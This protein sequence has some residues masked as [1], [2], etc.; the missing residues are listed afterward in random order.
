MKGCIITKDLPIY[1]ALVKRFN[2]NDVKATDALRR[3]TEDGVFTPSFI[4]WQQAKRKTDTVLTLETAQTVKDVNDI[5][6]FGNLL[7]PDGNDTVLESD[8]TFAEDY[9][10]VSDR[11]FCKHIVSN[12]L[13]D[14]VVDKLFNK[15]E[16]ANITKTEA[17]KKIRVIFASHLVQKVSQTKAISQD[18]FMTYW[19][20]DRF[21]SFYNHYSKNGDGLRSN[22]SEEDAEELATIAE[23]VAIAEEITSKNVSIEEQNLIATLKEMIHVTD[24]DL[25][26]SNDI[27]KSKEF[28][29]DVFKDSRLFRFRDSIVNDV[30]TTDENNAAQNE[31]IELDEEGDEEGIDTRADVFDMSFSV[32]DS[33][34]GQYKTYMLHLGGDLKTYFD[35]L[36]K[37]TSASVTFDDNGKPMYQYDVYNPIGIAD[38]MGAAQCVRALYT[39]SDTT[40]VDNFIESVKRIAEQ[41]PGLE[42][43]I[44][45][46]YDMRND[47]DFAYH[48]KTV[49]GKFVAAKLETSIIN[50]NYIVRVTNN[51]ANKTDALRTEFMNSFRNAILN[52][53][54]DVVKSLETKINNK[55]KEVNE[56]LKD[57]TKFVTI[58]GK[59]VAREYNTESLE[60]KADIAELV[61]FVTDITRMYFPNISKSNILGFVDLHSV[62]GVIN[63][64]DN[65]KELL[66]AIDEVRKGAVSSRAAFHDKQIQASKIRRQNDKIMSDRE[67]GVYRSDA[68]IQDPASVWVDSF[69]S[70]NATKA[71]IRFANLVVNHVEV[72]VNLNSRNA[73]G[74]TSSDVINNSMISYLNTMLNSTLNDK[75]N[76]NSPLNVYRDEIFRGKQYDF[77]NILVEHTEDG[78]TTP[79]LF[80]LVDGKY[81]QTDY[82]TNLLKFHLFNGVRN[83]DNGDSVLYAG[84]PE[85]DYIATAMIQFFNGEETIDGYDFSN[86]F[87]RTPSDAPK[88]FVM[89]APKFKYH[90]KNGAETISLY[91][92]DNRK[93]ADTKIKQEIQKI[94]VYDADAFPGDVYSLTS[95]KI[96]ANT[97][98]ALLK[99]NTINTIRINDST[100]LEVDASDKNKGYLT[101]SCGIDGKTVTVVAQGTLSKQDGKRTLT[102]CTL[103]GVESNGYGRITYP[104]SI[105][106]QLYNHF[107]KELLAKDEITQSLNKRHPIFKCLYRTAVQELQDAATAVD[108][109]LDHVNGVVKSENGNFSVKLEERKLFSQYHHKKLEY[110]DSDG[111]KHSAS[112]LIQPYYERVVDETDK[113]GNPTK[114]YYVNTGYKTLSG[115]VFRSDRFIV[116]GV[117]YME[118]VFGE[119]DN[120]DAAVNILY[121]SLYGNRLTIDDN[122]NVVVSENQKA[123]IENAIENYINAITNDATSRINQYSHLLENVP[124]NNEDIAEFILNYVIAFNNCNDILEG[125]SKFYKSPQDFL[126]RAKEGQGSGVPMGLLDITRQMSGEFHVEVPN[127]FLNSEEMQNIV[128][129][130]H[131]CKQYTTFRAV[132][133][134]NTVRQDEETKGVLIDQLYEKFKKEGLRDNVARRKAEEM[135]ARY[136][137][138]KTNDAQSYITF[139]EWIRRVAAKGQLHKYKPLIEAVLDESK[140]LSVADINEFIQV[141]KHFYYDLHYNSELKVRSPRQI[142]NA[143]FVLVP[144]FIKGTELEQVYNLMVENDIDQLNT[145]EA[146]KAGKSNVLTLWDNDGNLTEENIKD[147]RENVKDAS[148]AVE[149]F[150]YNYLYT[151]QETPNHL[152]SENRFGLQISKKIIDNISSTSQL[153]SRKLEYLNLY[154]QNIKDS[155]S[156]V[157]AEIDAPMDENGDIIVVDG[158]INGIDYTTFLKKMEDELIR[159]GADPNMLDYV[160]LDDAATSD[161]SGTGFGVNTRMPAYHNSTRL[162]FESIAQAV[163]NNAVTRQKLPG[164]HAAQITNIGWKSFG[165]N[166][167]KPYALRSDETKRI[168]KAEYNALS[169][170][171][172]KNYRDTRV[173]YSKRLRYHPDG[174]KYIQVM[175]P[176]SAFGLDINDSVYDSTREQ[177][178]KDGKSAQEIEEEIKHTMLSL[179]QAK[180]LDEFIGYRIPTEG[181]QSMAVMKVVGFTSEAQGSTIVIPDAW[182]AQTGSD[183]DIDSVYGIQFSTRKTS[184]GVVYKHN[185][186]ESDIDSEKDRKN[187]DNAYIDYVLR[188]VTK[189]DRAQFYEDIKLTRDNYKDLKQLSKTYEDYL[190]ELDEEKF[191]SK[192]RYAILLARDRGLMSFIDFKEL[193]VEERNSRESRNN[194]MLQIMI[195]I[196]KSD[197]SLEENLGQSR[198]TDITA[199]RNKMTPGYVEDERNGRAVN[200]FLDQA[201]FHSDA[202]SGLNLKAR[203]VQR[204]TF[205]SLCNTMQPELNRGITIVYEGDEARFLE[206]QKRFD[207]KVDG[208][209]LGL[210]SRL[211]DNRISVTHVKFGWSADN[212]NVLE[213]ILTSYSSQTTAHQLDIIKEGLVPNV[214]EFTFDVYKL[215]PDIGSDYD[216]AIG[217]M[218]QPAIT[219]L[220]SFYNRSNSIFSNE[221]IKPEDEVVKRIYERSGL[222]GAENI[223]QMREQLSLECDNYFGEEY[224][225]LD[226]SLLKYRIDSNNSENPDIIK[227]NNLF[228][229]LVIQEYQRLSSIANDVQTLARVCKADRFGAKQTLFQTR[230]VFEDITKLLSSSNPV[231]A[232]KNGVS[233][234]ERIY[235]GISS[236]VTETGDIDIS[237]YLQHKD[238][239]SEYKP[240]HYFLK[241]VSAVSIVVNQTLFPTQ[242]P[243]FVKIVKAI[244][245]NFRQDAV[246]TE[247]TYN[248]YEKY[249]MSHIYK[250]VDVIKSPVTY[251]PNV[252]VQPLNGNNR[253]EIERIFGYNRTP[254]LTIE[255]NGGFV[256]FV[257]SD[258]NEPNETDIANFAKL[259]PAQ[260]VYFIQQNFRDGLVCKYIDVNLV[261]NAN[262]GSE[263]FGAQ[264]LEFDEDKYD[265]NS[266]RRDFV[267]TFRNSNPLLVL[268]AMDIIKYSY[269]VEGNDFKRRVVNKVV[270]NQIII[271]PLGLYGS[272]IKEALDVKFKEFT[273]GDSLTESLVLEE[274]FIRSHSE[275]KEISHCFINSKD[276]AK[277]MPVVQN[278]AIAVLVNNKTEDFIVK[279]GIG[280]FTTSTNNDGEEVR[281]V[282]PNHYV[283]IKYGK[284]N[285][286][287]YKITKSKQDNV[288]YLTPLNLLQSNEQSEYSVNSANNKFPK[289][290]FYTDAITEYEKTYSNYTREDLVKIMTNLMKDSDGKYDKPESTKLNKL[291]KNKRLNLYDE[292]TGSIIILRTSIREHFKNGFNGSTLYVEMPFL[293]NFIAKGNFGIDEGLLEELD[294]R[295]YFIYRLNLDE[296]KDSNENYL[297]KY[298]KDVHKPIPAEFN[299]L[300]HLIERVRKRG[301]ESGHQGE[302]HLYNVY[303]VDVATSPTLSDDEYASS[304]VEELSET[305]RSL[306]RAANNGENKNAEDYAKKANRRNIQ[307]SVESIEQKLDDAVMLQAEHCVKAVESLLNDTH[308]L[309]FFEQDKETSE[310]M[311]MTDPR[312]MSLVRQYPGVRRQYLKNILQAHQIIDLFSFAKDYTPTEET[313]HLNLYIDKIKEALAKLENSE[314]LKQAE[315]LFVTDYL[316]KISKNPNVRN[317]IMSLLE[318]WHETGWATGLLNDI[319][320]T[321]NPLIQLITSDVMRD[322]RAKEMAGEETRQAFKNKMQELKDEASRLGLS[323]NWDK[324]VDA[325]GKWIEEYTDQ[326]V[327]DMNA[328][329]KAKDD[330]LAEYKAFNGPRYKKAE[331][332]EKYLQAKLAYNKWCLKYTNQEI[333]DEYYY[334][335]NK[336]VESMI[337]PKTGKF[338]PIYVEYCMLNDELANIYSQSVNGELDD[339][340]TIRKNDLLDK[341]RDL[342][343]NSIS[344]GNGEWELKRDYEPH[345]LSSDPEKRRIQSITSLSAASALNKFI[346]GLEKL[347]DEFFA[348]TE[349]FGFREQLDKYLKVIRHYE[350]SGLPE[351]ELANIDDYV[352]AKNW[353]RKN[354]YFEHNI[355]KLDDSIKPLTTAEE[356]S[357]LEHAFNK[358]I[359]TSSEEYP[360]LFQAALNYFKDNVG[361]RGNNRATYKQHV[362][363]A[364]ARDEYGVIDGRKL[365][366]DQIAS[367]KREQEHRFGIGESS[368][369]SERGIIKNASGEP[370]IYYNTFYEGLNVGGV[371]NPEYLAI[372]HDINEILRKVVDKNGIVK[373]SQLEQ[374][375]LAAVLSLMRKLGYEPNSRTF[376][377]KD[378]VKKHHGVKRKDVKK[379]QDF[380]DKNVEFEL[381]ESDF[382]R[383]KAEEAAA[384]LKGNEYYI[385]WCKMNKEWSEEKSTFVP[386]HLFWGQAKPKKEVENEFINKRKT[387]ALR[388]MLSGFAERPSKYYEMKKD[389]MIDTYGT[390]SPEYNKWYEENHIYNPNTHKMEPIVCWMTSEP[391]DKLPG[392]W[393]PSYKMTSKDIAKGK[394]NVNFK[395]NVGRAANFKRKNQREELKTKH[396]AVLNQQE[397]DWLASTNNDTFNEDAIPDSKYDRM[398]NLNTVEIKTK[399]YVQSV[400]SALAKTK[401]AKEYLERGH[402]PS[403][404]I[405]DQERLDKRFLKELAKGFGY[406]EKSTGEGYW[407]PNLN[408][409]TDRV[410]NM[411]MLSQLTSKETTPRPNIWDY[412]DSTAGHKQYEKDL[413]EYEKNEAEIKTK[414]AEIHRKLLD[415]DWESVIEDF[416]LKAAHYNAI[417]DNKNMLYFGQRLINDIQVYHTRHKPMFKPA[418]LSKRKQDEQNTRT[419]EKAVD[420]N[421]KDQ[422]DVFLHRLIFNQFKE[423]SNTK[424]AHFMN[425]LQ[426]ITSYNYMTLNIIGGVANV[427]I[428]DV[429]VLGERF[430]ND[431]FGHKN[432]LEA[433]AIYTQGV[434]SFFTNLGKETSISK[435]DAI[436]KGMAVVDYDEHRGVVMV[437]MEEWSKRIRDL[438]FAPLSMGEHFMQNR[439]MIALMLSHR[440][441]DNPKYGEPGKPKYVIQNLRE[442]TS[443]AF[444]EALGEVC[445]EEEIAEF[446]K[447][448]EDKKKQP[449]ELKDY[450]WFRRNVITD[451]VITRLSE[452]KQNAFKEAVEVYKK[453]REEEFNKSPKVYDELKLGDNGKMA[454]ADDSR[455]KEMNVIQEGQEVS[456][457]WKALGGF[458]QKVISVNKKIHGNYGKLDAAQI[459]SQW[460]GG[461]V[462]QY[463]KHIVPGLLKRYRAKGYF[464]EERGTIEKGSR[465]A[466]YDF[467]RASIAQMAEKA[468]LNE[469]ETQAL[470]GLQNLLRNISTY[471]HYL[472]LNWKFMSDEERGILARNL[473]DV[474]GV[475]A[476]VV[477]ALLLRLGFDDDDESFVYNFMLYQADRLSSEAFM[478]NPIGAMSEFNKL[479]SNPV[480]VQSIINDGLNAIKV[481]SGVIMEG[482]EYDPYF[483][484][485]RYAGKHKLGVYVQRRIPYWRNIIAIR[486]IA[487][488]NSY[489]KL[490]DNMLGILNVKQIAENIKGK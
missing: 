301:I 12:E 288:F 280:Y 73:S 39:M 410:P 227:H 42:G 96:Q 313:K 114:W 20:D 275:I 55:I 37:L 396:E 347:E 241:Y 305:D 229:F 28:F 159:I 225:V 76:P 293:D 175:L 380:I 388:V 480:A 446:R 66:S 164:F 213:E 482:D 267:K 113:Q 98:V 268:T 29:D 220:V 61:S 173:T 190:N 75:D 444:D 357:L 105:N 384:K 186:W 317:G 460:W 265:I 447:Y 47:M 3:V 25:S 382:N 170:A 336:L 81:V 136:A 144:R 471:F 94:P 387:I 14:I 110:V 107:K 57:K 100:S 383:F 329:T 369:Y 401:T 296:L 359:D 71:I 422:Y 358:G 279:K 425:V 115:N 487:D 87:L 373:T 123:A 440:V 417:Q 199:S 361:E 58:K 183:F 235:P 53:D 411:P 145:E 224:Y 285:E 242:H 332:F 167:N 349:R 421:L 464:N 319:Q 333:N 302:A 194:R 404:A 223:A 437:S 147:F 362:R 156:R 303:A 335:Y 125:D 423:E 120:A 124:N 168:T 127:A 356:L 138:I 97:L 304:L 226:A 239:N 445:S 354:A 299:H 328:L 381:S 205:L 207:I 177:G 228:D 282:A 318:G 250:R 350:D 54:D 126:K 448:I 243:E 270:D 399:E 134:K 79:G 449:N 467:L 33:H 210:V 91:A 133:I 83:Q 314:V 88:N 184:D 273:E 346:G 386:N 84:M 247:K 122:G 191:S 277:H 486:D 6:A 187:L 46:Y 48:C 104:S 352:Q 432:W 166:V 117:N 149:T 315:E 334:R 321:N 103:L 251:I 431:Y 182:V 135:M 200:N 21:D 418:N 262:R 18:D 101:L 198:F 469:G 403:R 44:Q 179:L 269:V 308:G 306:R 119:G 341:I 370:T 298:T 8:R 49:F 143:E 488:N 151:Q 30:D 413:A 451:F 214:N 90:Y 311:K 158:K 258:I 316:A 355:Y 348:R 188:N 36:K 7:N 176:C 466:F 196:L 489:Y 165:L 62:K 340:L 351:S 212:K 59:V 429:N 278:G 172:K 195:D 476:G 290:E 222:S 16:K 322:I 121:G 161:K 2:G 181:K 338:R 193:Q 67:N 443:R 378:G 374:E 295:W 490:G 174:E 32:Y 240:M 320:D 65:I 19:N 345:E 398:L 35:T 271:E 5:I 310:W 43:L 266:V 419:Y 409:D 92:L 343:S 41:V 232:T 323:I 260:K 74:K 405:K 426:S 408:Y 64:I 391:T 325:N 24:K 472:N 31:S 324:M 377:S 157:C 89:K 248:D 180:G 259:T 272:G 77:S 389:E 479:W 197:E 211:D 99:G 394:E 111:T 108:S 281:I 294:G 63:Q 146:S 129:G 283:K 416:I 485:G 360:K 10:S 412:E 82:A 459:E 420:K 93:E 152:D 23:Y 365:T 215:F 4:A 52:A 402:L 11:T 209:W 252:G 312:V 130:L 51:S 465:I 395:D 428:G 367:I 441:V 435:V 344:L 436:I 201:A 141:Q 237:R 256:P 458:K 407:E 40:S 390:G 50:G 253:D 415:R 169:S 217:F 474:I 438:G 218:T 376:D 372:V 148:E 231:F 379:V 397:E 132:T 142:K 69:V 230:K 289:A 150:S 185:Y 60:Y 366:D 297:R 287:L 442:F 22:I 244:E 155:F 470:T 78:V 291:K 284:N 434:G 452:E 473:G 163:W 342:K 326:L 375:D 331:L 461:L 453:N 456:D 216:T 246:L 102:D 261:N 477:V 450:V 70:D 203:S 424:R 154:A 9:N 192:V 160:T 95:Q 34:D 45:F 330:A 38:T 385:A 307:N 56:A 430:A 72:S 339:A 128:G 286:V 462:M 371:S 238:N 80:K 189:E 478:W 116:R 454:F 234:L 337:N 162:K 233:F 245:D 292:D 85:G 202:I 118:G 68:E 300:S 236:I 400:L 427:S 17:I 106:D 178:A 406:I 393:V 455:L 254:D 249:I 475:L 15:R 392:D 363:N 463:H 468:G 204:D 483:V 27:S 255:V 433:G 264:T 309:N 364:D 327:E 481:I 153:Y 274:N 86:Y 263:K 112:G 13:L 414:N 484:S 109:T 137:D 140:P 26:D 139:E 353:V 171:D 221:Y 1:K 208:E 457:A 276:R 219:E 368:M 206:L 439:S 131:N 257:V